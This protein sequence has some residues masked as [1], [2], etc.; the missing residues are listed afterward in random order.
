M[1]ATILV[2]YDEIG[3]KGKNRR[4]FIDKLRG[5]IRARMGGF[6]EVRVDAP[7]G[8]VFLECAADDADEIAQRLQRVPG[9][10]S[11]SVGRTVEP[12]F[13]EMARLGTAWITPRLQ[14]GRGLTFRVRTRRADKTFP[15]TSMDIDRE[16]GGRILEGLREKG[17]E[18]SLGKPDFTLEIEIGAQRTVMFSQRIPGLGGLPVGSAGDAL[19]LLSGGIDSPVAMFQ[20]MRRGCRVH[21]VFFDNQPF[22]GRGGYDKVVRLC[23]LLGR[24]QEGA[25]LFVVPFEDIQVAIRDHC[26]PANRVVLYRRMMYRIAQSIAQRHRCLALVTGE[27]LGQV[28]SQTLENLD[29]V[30][31]V[32]AGSVFRPLIGLDKQEIIRQARSI[33]AYEISIE[34]HPDCCSVFMPN[35]PATRARIPELEDDETR[36]PWAALMEEALDRMETLAPA[37]L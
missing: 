16:V 12:D 25:R 18:V 19:G 11:L 26:R 14:E 5:N 7:H 35:R 20:I 28:A 1:T 21:A 3:L 29:A 15:G 13:D 36:Y 10:A 23:R 30:S 32:V 24:Y 34:P 4:F 17:L 31:R 27:S 22:M 2:R 8:R 37:P 33:G 6:Q 9:I